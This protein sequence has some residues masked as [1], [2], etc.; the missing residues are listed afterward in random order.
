MPLLATPSAPT[1][2]PGL[3]TG[4]VFTPASIALRYAVDRPALT[5]Q[6]RSAVSVAGRQLLL[7]GR[8]QTGK[9]TLLFREI[10]R[11]GVRHVTVRC[12]RGSDL[13]LLLQAARAQVGL[14]SADP[15]TIVHATALDLGQRSTWLIV[16]DV[17]LLTADHRA[18]ALAAAKVFS[19]LGARFPDLKLVLVAAVE[20]L[21][22]LLGHDHDE[23]LSR[24]QEVHV[25]MMTERELAAIVRDGARTLAVPAGPAPE[26]IAR[27]SGGQPA[28][29]HELALVA[30]EHAAEQMSAVDLAAVH[31]AV[32]GHLAVMPAAYRHRFDAALDGDLGDS[33]LAVLDALATFGPAGARLMDLL[34]SVGAVDAT[35][36][37]RVRTTLHRLTDPERGGLLVAGPRD[38]VRFADPRIRS[39]QLMNA[40][41]R[42]LTRGR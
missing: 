26:L 1:P 16:E 13:T 27:L 7:Y 25:P 21:H 40:Y 11:I 37:E 41:L 36:S 23:Q 32:A 29:A 28:V 12:T 38:V 39:Y 42:G 4:D 14:P 19:D 5:R 22:E 8:S 18:Q 2:T 10:D 33:G 24:V 34:T 17:H 9:S 3:R 20:D 15:A 6:L 35:R 30:F 31:R